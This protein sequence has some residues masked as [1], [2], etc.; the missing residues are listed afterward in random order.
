MN[1]ATAFGKAGNAGMTFEF[2]LAAVTQA[3]R[4]DAG[5]FICLGHG[6]S[7]LAHGIIGRT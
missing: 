2:E 4:R 7:F 5:G 3:H 6:F 1:A